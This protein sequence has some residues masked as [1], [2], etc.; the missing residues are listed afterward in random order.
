MSVVVKFHP[1]K[2]RLEL[3]RLDIV[4]RIYVVEEQRAPIGIRPRPKSP[5]AP[6]AAAEMVVSQGRRENCEAADQL[7]PTE[8]L[9][10]PGP[11]IEPSVVGFHASVRGWLWVV[12]A[13]ETRRIKG[14][15]A[16]KSRSL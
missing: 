6:L 16:P 1:W 11:M 3:S 15:W 13:S 14:T 7:D 12:R 2:S 4:T 5:R 8:G 10:A 9:L